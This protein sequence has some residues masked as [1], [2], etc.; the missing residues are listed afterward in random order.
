MTRKEIIL[1]MFLTQY[2]ILSQE[3]DELQRNVRYR[4][5]TTTD[6]LEL[7]IAIERFEMLKD[8]Q[9]WIFAVMRIDENEEFEKLFHKFE[10]EQKK[11]IMF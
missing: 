3:I 8:M 4:R 10:A 7:I 5:I 11:K 6:C 2:R 1:Q 9:S